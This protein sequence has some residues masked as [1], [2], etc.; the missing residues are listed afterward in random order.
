MPA[1]H[2]YRPKHLALAIALALGCA[3]F[4][5]AQALS[6]D[7]ESPAP[8]DAKE[9]PRVESKRDPLAVLQAFTK[10]DS[11]VAKQI[12]SPESVVK[13]TDVNDLIIVKNSGSFKGLVDGGGGINSIH[14]DASD[15]GE[16]GDT[17]NFAGLL[18]SQ[19]SWTLNSK[20]DFKDGVVVL[21]DG[22]LTNNGKILGRAIAAGQLFNKG[23]IRGHVEV[24]QS[25]TF[26]GAGTIGSLAVHGRIDVNKMHGAPRVKGNLSLSETGVLAYEV[27]P[28]SNSQTIKVGGTASL[29]GSTLKIVAV[30]GEY[31]LT[32]QHTII[33]AKKVEGE[34]GKV[35]N[36]LAF[37]TPTLQYNK[38]N[39]GLTY[40]RNEVR[41]ESLA[42][43]DNGRE[44]GKSVIEPPRNIPEVH[45]PSD[46]ENTVVA[47]VT[48]PTISADSSVA[49]Q[50]TTVA[51]TPPAAS[52]PTSTASAPATP[53]KP[54]AVSNAAVTTLLASNKETASYALEQL[55]GSSNANLAK[56]TLSSV[57]PVSGSLLSAMRQLGT[58]NQSKR[59]NAPRLAAGSEDNGRVWLQALGHGGKLDRDIEPL[60]HSTKG[61]LLGADW[62]IDEEWRLGVMGGKS[63]T[64]LDSR[65]LDGNLDSWHLGAYALR[66]NGPMSLRLGATYGSHDGSTARRV[67]FSGFSDRPKGS[68]DASTQQAF[69]EVGYNLGRYNVSFE[70]FASIGYQRYQRDG[71]TEKGGAAALKV[72]EQAQSN[73][74]S[75]FGLRLAK[76]ETLDNG[77]RLTPRLSAGWKHTYGELYTHTRQRLVTGG[78]NYTV[79][80]AEL[81][82][83]SLLVDAGLDLGVSANHSVGVG[84][85]GEA[86]SDSRSYGVMG[87]WRIAF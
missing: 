72:H 76:V 7:T 30:P 67:A 11:T 51:D 53:Q 42:D 26:A 82:R 77:M 14:L 63:G 2:T 24:E 66:Q 56:A 38:K 9:A 79:Y 20:S 75:T 5:N 87:Q 49:S 23:D 41:I 18:S 58:D 54:A 68:Y 19:G 71:Y 48:P 16:L 32:S 74:N 40:A 59:N 65:E 27:N 81:D 43:T 10:A 50:P 52:K 73:M 34:F 28:D 13:G 44:F 64:R 80:G 37:M 12:D 3:E 8:I 84:L 69:A 17:R 62:N 86:G 60:Q 61:L 55:A 29:G 70:P 57:D 36:D 25:G 45:I 1:Q 47:E 39:V 35:I 4:P 6:I 78:N 33:E 85:T 22:T 46:S 21:N 15:G 31:P 83:N